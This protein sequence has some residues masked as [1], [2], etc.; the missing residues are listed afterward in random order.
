VRVG[1][2]YYKKHKKG[3]PEP[4]IWI[5]YLLKPDDKRFC[6]RRDHGPVLISMSTFEKMVR[7]VRKDFK[8]GAWWLKK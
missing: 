5:D 2:V 1:P 4:G 8:K 6:K 3:H 7:R